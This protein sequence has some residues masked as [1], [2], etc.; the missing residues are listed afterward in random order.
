MSDDQKKH[1]PM[2]VASFPV[3]GAVESGE[4][5]HGN[6]PMTEVQAAQLRELCEKKGEAF[7]ATLTQ[8]Q[9]DARIAALKDD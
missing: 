8:D 2:D 5:P 9:A 7:D 6:E 1:S 4:N 3:G